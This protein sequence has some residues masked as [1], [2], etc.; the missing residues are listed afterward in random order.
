MNQRITP[1]QAADLA[2]LFVHE[3]LPKDEDGHWDTDALKPRLDKL[4]PQQ[5]RTIYDAFRVLKKATLAD[6]KRKYNKIEID[7]DAIQNLVLTEPDGEPPTKN[8]W[9]PF[10]HLIALAYYLGTKI[11]NVFGW[12]DSECLSKEIEKYRAEYDDNDRRYH[13]VLL[14]V[15]IP[16]MQREVDEAKN[17]LREAEEN[18]RKALE[19]SEPLLLAIS[20]LDYEL[21]YSNRLQY[22]QTRVLPFDVIKRSTEDNIN[23][24]TFHLRG[25]IDRVEEMSSQLSEEPHSDQDYIRIIE[26]IK[27]TSQQLRTEL[28]THFDQTVKLKDEAVKARSKELEILENDRK[29]LKRKF[30]FE[31]LHT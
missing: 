20:R 28:D 19:E 13:Q 5:K 12:V 31:K 1:N 15:E 25:L 23:D 26:L 22:S 21:R 14:P 27:T 8:G 2:K 17:E 3:K 9:Y 16:G 29:F 7:S 24:S 30:R 10:K 18:G 4:S 11:L 6:F